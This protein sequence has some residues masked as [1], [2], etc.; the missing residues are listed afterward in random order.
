MSAN[1][2]F[3]GKSGVPPRISLK[4]RYDGGEANELPPE[5]QKKSIPIS[6]PITSPPPTKTEVEP[7]KPKAAPAP[8]PVIQRTELKD[9]TQAMSAMAS[10]FA[11]KEE[12]SE[13]DASSF[14][15]VPKPIERPVREAAPPV[16]RAAAVSSPP[17]ASTYSRSTAPVSKP[18]ETPATTS[19]ASSV[20][21]AS[22]PT[23]SRAPTSGLAEGL[24][25]HFTD[26]KTAQNSQLNEISELKGQVSE[27]TDLVRQ[28]S[29][30]LDS[31]A[32]SQS[33]R[34]RR[35]ELEVENL[36]E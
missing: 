14:E 1:E 24:K 2:W 5:E 4:G 21:A 31:L 22:E 36:R 12:E 8:E 13:D 33:E 23:T 29:S 16:T 9:N 28:L 20:P 18:S 26:I 10:K 7:P 3:G 11:D 30:R 17:I 34:I 6:T 35:V 32:G 19:A 25:A 27:L 15:E